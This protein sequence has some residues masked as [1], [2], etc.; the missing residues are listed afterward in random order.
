MGNEPDSVVA[1]VVPCTPPLGLQ[2]RP[3]CLCTYK[4]DTAD[5]YLHV[6]DQT[7]ARSSAHLHAGDIYFYNSGGDVSKHGTVG[8]YNG[9]D[10]VMM[11]ERERGGMG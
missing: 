8:E 6:V 2:Q 3:K 9:I 1:Y 4:V 11:T 7:R 5:T 10:T